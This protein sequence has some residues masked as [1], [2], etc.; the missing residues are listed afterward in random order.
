M[1]I[2]KIN[3]TITKIMRNHRIQLENQEHCENLKIT[4]KNHE[5]HEK[6]P[7]EDYENHEHLTFNS[8]ITKTMKIYN[9]IRESR[10]S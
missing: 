2:K 7:C 4:C 9:S 6:V 3:K 1:K 5:N 10:K 8:R